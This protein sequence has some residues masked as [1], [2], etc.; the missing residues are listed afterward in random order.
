MSIP[1]KKSK[2]K[3][4]RKAFSEMNLSR[5]G[6]VGL[7]VSVVLLGLALNIGKV[8]ELVGNARYTA[9]FAEA[10][11]LRG[12]DDVRVDGLKVGSVDSVALDGYQVKVTFSLSGV[13]VGS[14][15]TAEI[16]SNNALGSKFLAINPSGTGDIHNIPLSQT[17]AGISVNQELGELT[18]ETTKIDSNQLAASFGSLSKVLA[19]TPTQFRSA[20]AGVSA[21]SQTISSRDADLQ[22]LLQKASSVSSVLAARNQQ[23]TGIVSDGGALFQELQQRQ[24]VIAQL[25]HN[26][27]LATDQM[28]A[29]A[30][31]NQASFGPALA[32]L[33]N[34]ALLLKRYRSTLDYGLKT[35]G[36]YAR[37]LGESVGSGPFFQAYLANVTSPEDLGVGGIGGLVSSTLGSK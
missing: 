2:R 6:L 10:G 19:A 4:P 24:V 35:T 13:K 32:Q 14:Q 26:V 21:L 9:N 23:I 12:G 15:S 3:G 1:R 18:A 30:H 22:V 34:A 28:T 31:D 7:I 20:L 27:Q 25:L 29:L 5:I 16:K 37:A 17:D 33:R 36:V 8:L 11:G